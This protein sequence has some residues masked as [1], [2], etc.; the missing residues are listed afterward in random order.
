MPVE[1]VAAYEKGLYEYLDVQHKEILD[2]IRT[3]GKFEK[4]TEEKLAAALKQYTND[5]LGK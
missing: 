2:T 3:T 5:F 1:R 4:E